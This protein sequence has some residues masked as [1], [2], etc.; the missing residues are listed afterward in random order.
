MLVGSVGGSFQPRLV[1][2]MTWKRKVNA[3]RG[4]TKG[5]EGDVAL[6]TFDNIP[7]RVQ[8]NNEK[9]G[10]T[11]LS[12][13]EYATKKSTSREKTLLAFLAGFYFLNPGLLKRDV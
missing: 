13:R 2:E 5:F 4:I 8:T 3:S 6:L 7:V 12:W 11:L 1:Y 9:I 10:N